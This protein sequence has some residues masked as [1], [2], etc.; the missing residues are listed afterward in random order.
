MIATQTNRATRSRRKRRQACSQKP[1]ALT[2]VGSPAEMPPPTP[3]SAAPGAAP[4]RIGRSLLVAIWLHDTPNRRTCP[5][6]PHWAEGTA[7]EFRGAAETTIQ[8][9]PTGFISISRFRL[10][11]TLGLVE[12][13]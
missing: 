13:I 12:A 11:V 8:C 1:R 2:A 3:T 6:T 10:L 5:A 9:P 7:V 4:E